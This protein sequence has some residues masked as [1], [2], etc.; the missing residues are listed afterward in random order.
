V[1]PPRR[2]K[3]QSRGTR[4][5]SRH[6]AVAGAAFWGTHLDADADVEPINVPGDPTALVLS[7]GPAPL[8]GR[9]MIAEHY[10]ATVYDKSAALAIALA[11]AA[12]LLSSDADEVL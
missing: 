6:R 2:R 11:A 10:F 7:L 9:E 3:S 12:D 5:S 1:S 8:P 4:S